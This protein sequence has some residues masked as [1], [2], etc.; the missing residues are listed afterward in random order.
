MTL[1][2]QMQKNS[3]EGQGES[4]TPGVYLIF[5]V[6]D[7]TKS[8]VDFKILFDPEAM[9]R[10]GTLKFTTD[11]WRVKPVET[12]TKTATKTAIDE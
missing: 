11:K 1:G 5:R 9:R 12:A 2:A 6:F 10:D 4:S 8:N 3:I 7:V